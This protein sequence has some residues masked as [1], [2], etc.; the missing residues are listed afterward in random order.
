MALPGVSVLIL[1]V[2]EG[3]HTFGGEQLDERFVDLFN[4]VV[5]LLVV[6]VDGTFYCGDALGGREWAASDV[7]LV[8]QQKI[9]AVLF[10]NDGEQ[11][12]AHFV[13]RRR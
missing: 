10:A 8:P 12:V 7:F 4:R 5:A 9:E 13:A 6:A 3:R 11:T 2:R 1:R